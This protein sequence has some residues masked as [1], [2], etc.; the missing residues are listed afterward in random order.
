MRHHL[1]TENDKYKTAILIKETSFNK[2]DLITN[3]TYPLSKLGVSD[4]DLIAFTLEYNAAKK[5][6][7][8]L[9]QSYLSTLLKALDSLGVT[10]LYCA[11]AAYFKALAGV[12]KSEGNSGYVLPCKIKGYAHMQVVL[13]VNHSSLLYNPNNQAALDLSLHA[14]ATHMG[15]EYEELGLDIL[16]HEEYYSDTDDIREALARLHQYPALT[17]DIEAFSLK[18]YSAGIG[19]IGFAWDKHSGIALRCDYE[20]LDEPTEIDV[21]DKKDSKYKKKLAYGRKINNEPVKAALR[22]FFE[23]YEGNLI[24]HNAT[25]DV[26]VIIYELWMDGDITNHE[27]LLAGLEVMTRHFDCTKLITYLAT[28][29]CAGNKLSLKD[30]AHEFAGNYA[31]DEI[32]DIR[33]IPED[34]LLRY[35]LIDCLCTWYAKEKN[36]PK[37]VEDDQE[38]V[39]LGIFKESLVTLIQMELTGMPMCMQEVLKGERELQDIHNHHRDHIQASSLVRDAITR[40]QESWLETDYAKRKAN[41]K[42]PE[43]IKKRLLKD[44]LIKAPATFPRTFNPNSGQQAAVLLYEVMELPIIETT[45]TGL[46]STD[47][48]TLKALINHVPNTP[49]LTP[50][51]IQERCELIGHIRGQ[52]GVDKILSTFIPAFKEAQLGK[53][54]IYYLFGSFNLG[55]TKSGRLSSS[56]PNLQNLPSGSTYAKVVKRMFRGNADWLFCGSDYN[57]LEDVINALLTK[58]PNK[59]RIL[60]EGMDGHTYRM[61][62][63]WPHHF[64]DVDFNALTKSIVNSFK[65]PFDKLRSASKPVSFALQYQGT[66]H[67]LMANC[68]FSK[69]EAMAIEAN[70]HKLYVVSNEYTQDKLLEASKCGYVTLA[71]GLKLRTPLLARTIL[72]TS[73]TPYEAQAEGRTAGNALSGQSYGLVNCKAANVFM[74]RVRNSPYRLEIKIS[75]QIHDAIYLLVAN[76]LEVIE[77]VNRNLVECMCERIEGELPEL[78][79]PTVKLNSELDLFPSWD[80]P[81]TIPNN[82]SMETIWRMAQE[83]S[84]K[85]AA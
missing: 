3:Y 16:K 76:R 7:A 49:F 18:H 48:D 2:S 61:M 58:D 41:A 35:N 46:P 14:L 59:L 80:N 81:L 74:K 55:G 20:P 22:E 11:D 6:P 44:L 32:N 30:V 23:T 50:D 1:F 75:A 62:H 39:Y 29:N 51:E 64:T 10:T 19:T 43:G 65:K 33:L 78:S 73:K 56:K 17:A 82:A 63:Y 68:G 42:K 26:K 70:F 5:A 12:R 38:H 34:T 85:K 72:N 67:T 21:W 77:W 52:L 71:Y 9:I 27:G 54:G 47:D 25:Y 60:E 66:Y 83:H 45:D 69:E 15:G 84:L 79:H 31:Q 13:G 37:M 28:N 4:S 24:W 53:D 40:M 57:A 8:A 36:Y